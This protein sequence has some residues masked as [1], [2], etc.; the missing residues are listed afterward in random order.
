M[1][2]DLRIA[3]EI[4][5]RHI[6]GT[7]FRREKSD[8]LQGNLVRENRLSDSQGFTRKVKEHELFIKDIAVN[9]KTGQRIYETEYNTD[10]YGMRRWYIRKKAKANIILLGSS[11]FFGVGLAENQNVAFDLSELVPDRNVIDLSISGM[12][13]TD[14]VAK[15]SSIESKLKTIPQLPTTVITLYSRDHLWWTDC[16]WI[17]LMHG[18]MFREW[19]GHKPWMSLRHGQLVTEGLI[20]DQ[21]PLLMRMAPFLDLLGSHVWL[22]RRVEWAQPP[23]EL[24]SH[25]YVEVRQL[26]SKILPVQRFSVFMAPDPLH[27]DKSGMSAQLK[28]IGIEVFD[29]D[30][31]DLSLIT[32]H[33]SYILDDLHPTP[34]WNF[35]IAKLLVDYHWIDTH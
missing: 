29:F 20:R 33:E 12:G 19:V 14:F 15:F 1:S 25:V 32:D 34:Q 16:N 10:E 21:H 27:V 13:P 9:I 4:Q 6:Y 26:L 30:N 35:A 17:C 24:L 18:P 3:K 11:I 23:Y 7:T 2:E 5:R 31:H 22:D 8:D 28:K